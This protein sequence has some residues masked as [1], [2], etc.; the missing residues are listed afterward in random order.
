MGKKA[1]RTWDGT[2]VSLGKIRKVED[3]DWSEVED[4]I[5]EMEKLRKCKMWNRKGKMK[6]KRDCDK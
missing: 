3:N 2:R 1:V 5:N 6:V 4:E